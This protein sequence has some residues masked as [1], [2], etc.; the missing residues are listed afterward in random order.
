MFL[1]IDVY[2]IGTR[3]YMGYAYFWPYE[4]R[5]VLRDAKPSLRRKIHRELLRLALLQY[6]WCDEAHGKIVQRII[7]EKD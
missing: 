4:Y 2:L 1:K 6:T 5:H 7:A 3:F